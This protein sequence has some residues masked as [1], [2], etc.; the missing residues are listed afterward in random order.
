MRSCGRQKASSSFAIFSLQSLLDY[1]VTSFPVLLVFRRHRRKRSNM[2]RLNKAQKQRKLEASEGG[3]SRT[4]AAHIRMIKGA[5]LISFPNSSVLCRSRL[6]ASAEHVQTHF[7]R[8]WQR[9][10]ICVDDK[11][12]RG[13]CDFEVCEIEREN[14]L[15]RATTVAVH[16]TLQSIPISST[17]TRHRKCA[18]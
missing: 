12:V 7:S 4:S 2:L 3:K 5:C 6:I 16:F 18:V 13:A 9:P 8:G 17:R 11:T 14:T 10:Q 15:R 1:S